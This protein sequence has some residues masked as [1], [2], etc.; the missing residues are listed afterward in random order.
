MSADGYIVTN[1]HVVEYSKLDD[2]DLADMSLA[3]YADQFSSYL[4]SIGIEETY[5]N[6]YDFLWSYMGWLNVDRSLG[7]P[8]PR[9]S[10]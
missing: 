7:Q 10:R 4:T 2:Q 5:D 6:A 8:K 3:Y 1:A 9:P